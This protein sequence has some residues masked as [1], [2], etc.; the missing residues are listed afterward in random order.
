MFPFTVK[1]LS[2]TV[3]SVLH[4]LTLLL[5]TGGQLEVRPPKDDSC[6]DYVFAHILAWLD[7]PGTP[8]DHRGFSCAGLT[9]Q[10]H[11][12]RRYLLAHRRGYP[13]YAL[14]SC[15]GSWP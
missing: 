15:R 14:E 12:S 1:A 5:E 4:L 10:A 13:A 6:R 3:S 11:Q 9:G 2:A 8:E 7:Q